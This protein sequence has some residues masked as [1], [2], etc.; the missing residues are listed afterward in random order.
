MKTSLITANPL[1]YLTMTIDEILELLKVDDAELD[2]ILEACGWSGKT[3]FTD[4]EADTLLAV[5]ASHDEKN[6]D[7]IE[8]YLRNIAH[9]VDITGTQF[10]EIAEAITHAGGLLLDYRD[11]FW[12]ICQR[13]KDGVSPQEAVLPPQPVVEDTAPTAED[14]PTVDDLDSQSEEIDDFINQQADAAMVTTLK[15]IQGFADM[16]YEEQE[17][18]KK[19]FLA[20]YRQK[21][22]EK[23]LDPEFQAQ[24]TARMQGSL[25]QG[26]K[27]PSPAEL[28]GVP[29]PTPLLS[30]NS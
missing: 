29:T 20:R 22:A 1:E 18:L 13:V 19:M 27:K 14:T 12:D 4:D 2:K 21:L 5:K 8:G 9:N 15:Q 16:A 6:R 26:A 17:R 23:L 30:S 11:Q 25:D 10:D 24:F 3:E 7:Y 28:T